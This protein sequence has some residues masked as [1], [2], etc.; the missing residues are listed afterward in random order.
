LERRVSAVMFGIEQLRRPKS[1]PLRSLLLLVVTLAIFVGFG[2]LL[3][4]WHFVLMIVPIILFHELGHWLA[5]KWFGYRNVRMFFIPFLGAAVQG[6]HHNIDGW[7]KVV[8]SM[9]GPVPGILLSPLILWLGYAGHLPELY[10]IAAVTVALN[11]FNLLP[12]IP[13]DGGWVFHHVLFC[14]HWALE[15]IARLLAVAIIF[16]FCCIQN[17]WFLMIIAVPVLISLPLTLKVSRLA[18]DLRGR[19]TEAELA[20]VEG[21]VPREPIAE[22]VEQLSQRLGKGNADGTMVRF[23]LHVYETLNTKPPGLLAAAG[24]LTAYI[25]TW[26][27]ALGVL[28]VAVLL[29]IE[30]AK[31]AA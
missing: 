1:K 20:E 17:T 7:K 25:G 21:E 31:L 10:T 26:V 22:I 4:P 6:S 28:M 16:A 5:M 19:W 13:L 29:G 24:I 12:V 23:T 3:W 30:A 11:L 18:Y 14:R 27:F 2:M 15:F 9:M 8:V